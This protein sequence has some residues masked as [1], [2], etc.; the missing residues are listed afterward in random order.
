VAGACLICFF[1]FFCPRG[2]PHTG[3]DKR[4]HRAV[5]ILGLV[6]KGPPYDDG[7]KLAYLGIMD[8][9]K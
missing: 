8:V 6:D 3:S 9:S 1:S 5:Q 2:S 4:D 7:K